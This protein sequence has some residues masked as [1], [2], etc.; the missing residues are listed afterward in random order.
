V[1]AQAIRG[2]ARI[3]RLL[4]YTVVAALGCWFAHLLLNVVVATAACDRGESVWWVYPVSA[5]AAVGALAALL[6]TI[7]L[8]QQASDADDV[9][10][11]ITTLMFLAVVLDLLILLVIV[12][13]AVQV[14]RACT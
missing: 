14:A 10:N 9:S 5:L 3:T 11:R 7:N 2:E 1:S 4:V 12:A 6:T 8:R 13:Q